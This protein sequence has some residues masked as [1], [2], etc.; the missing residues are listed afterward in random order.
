M[1]YNKERIL[2]RLMEMIQIDSVSYK[3]GPMTDYLQKY[4][5]DRGYEVY[6]DQAGKAVGGDHSGNLLIHIPGTMEGE[7][8]CLNAHQDTVEPG[9]GIVPV[10]EDGK[11]K[12]S[13]DTILAADDKSGIAIMLELLEVLKET[14]TPHRDMYYLFTICEESGMYGAKNFDYSKIP[15][16][17]IFSLDGA[18]NLGFILKSGAGKDVLTITFHGKSAHG[19]I[20]PEKG[21]NAINVAA[22]A[23]SK[24][25]F[26]RIDPETTSNIGRIEGGAAT[27]IVTDKVTFTCEVRSHSQAQIEAQ[28]QKIMDACQE[29]A[30]EFGA[31]VDI[32]VDHFC[33]P[34]KPD[35]D[36]FLTKATVRA[37]ELEGIT[38]EY[39]ISNGSG[40]SNIFSGHGFDCSGISTGMFNVHT[41]D[42]YLDLAVFEQAFNVTWRIVTGCCV[43]KGKK[44]PSAASF[45]FTCPLLPVSHAWCKSAINAS[46][47]IPHT[48]ALRK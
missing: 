44:R 9:I 1:Q 6:R 32:D 13:G 37:L 38:P 27:N 29:A 2:S 10:L 30:A 34:H 14:G 18:G 47:F 35:M 36:G 11:L 33:P 8:I 25:K 4:F 46:H 24:V 31:T 48:L 28:V 26:G 16:K 42:E 43:S 45:F 12:S 23:I 40:D 39:H 5:E 22:L 3:E 20:E 15:T 41:T 17:N 19:G 7:S 21:I